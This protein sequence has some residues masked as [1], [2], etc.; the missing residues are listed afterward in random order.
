MTDKDWTWP[1]GKSFGELTAVEKQLAA[2][3]AGAQLERELRAMAP[4][5]ERVMAMAEVRATGCGIHPV[6]AN[7]FCQTCRAHG[8]PHPF[9]QAD[10]LGPC[11][12]C[13]G[14]ADG[15]CTICDRPVCDDDASMKDYDRFCRS[16]APHPGGM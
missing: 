3:R 10:E 13:G 1:K 4:A 16:C 5:I 11:H 12:I 6:N 15:T 7:P 9:E 8:N 14:D 2:Q